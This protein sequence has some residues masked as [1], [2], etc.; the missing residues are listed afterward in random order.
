MYISVCTE[1]CNQD[2]GI[3]KLSFDTDGGVTLVSC[4][5]MERSFDCTRHDIFLE[6]PFGSC[7]CK[8]KKYFFYFQHLFFL[9]NIWKCLS[10]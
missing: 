8:G 7:E 2:D 6:H 4:S 1:C 3:C 5:Q 9:S 10:D